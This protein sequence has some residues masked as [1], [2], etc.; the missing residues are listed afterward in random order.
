[1]SPG[2]S[3]RRPPPRPLTTPRAAPR[4]DPSPSLRLSR[5]TGP[6]GG[7]S[8]QQPQCSLH[9]PDPLPWARLRHSCSPW[10][11]GSRARPA[12]SAP[13]AETKFCPQVPRGSQPQ[14]SLPARPL[15]TFPGPATPFPCWDEAHCPT[16]ALPASN[17][18]AQRA[19]RN[20]A[21]IHTP[22]NNHPSQETRPR[23]H[24]TARACQAPSALQLP[25]AQPLSARRLLLRAGHH[26]PAAPAL[27]QLL[28]V[29]H[30][31]LSAHHC[32]LT[33]SLSS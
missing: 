4:P 24:G 20:P 1:M 19:S 21:T 8:P 7:L 13:R 18:Q 17:Q 30:P 25:P 31:S 32:L 22:K 14:S 29:H 28:T 27:N 3:P 6:R 23:P 10:S 15:C 9:V 12:P 11:S 16:H 26:R 5:S 33:G 2:L